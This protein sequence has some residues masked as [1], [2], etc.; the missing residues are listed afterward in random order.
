M[1]DEEERRQETESQS[2]RDA[3]NLVRRA[4]ADEADAAAARR[5]FRAHGLPRLEANDHVAR[6][7][8][9]TEVVVARRAAVIVERHDAGNEPAE[10]GGE[11]YL[12]TQ[13]LLVLGRRPIAVDL[14]E[15]DELEVVGERLLVR[16]RTGIGL[17]IQTGGPRLLRTEVAAA[18][19]ARRT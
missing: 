17:A 10:S 5:R 8:R 9:Q 14:D 4:E 3:E 11:L 15:V 1:R 12:T 19:E 13:R 2:V 7:L 18:M 16:L 6:W